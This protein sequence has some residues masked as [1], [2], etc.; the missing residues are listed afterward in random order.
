MNVLLGQLAMAAGIDPD[1]EFAVKGPFL[2]VTAGTLLTAD[3][4]RPQAM[5]GADLARS[6]KA[7]PGDGLTLLASTTEGA[8]NAMDVT[9][10]GEI[11]R[12]HV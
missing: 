5:L 7:R 2:T 6:L 12:A 11:G 4:T 8:M 3:A 10:A 1:S 9:V